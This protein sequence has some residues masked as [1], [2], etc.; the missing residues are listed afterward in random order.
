[1]KP[2]YIIVAI[3]VVVIILYLY[4]YETYTNETYSV[5]S[6]YNLI[7]VDENG[8]MSTVDIHPPALNEPHIPPLTN[9]VYTDTSGNLGVM[10]YKDIGGS[11]RNI[12]TVDLNN[13]NNNNFSVLTPPTTPS[14]TTYT[15]YFSSSTNCIFTFYVTM[16]PNVYPV[17][18]YEFKMNGNPVNYVLQDQSSTARS[19]T[20]KILKTFT[21]NLH[22]PTPTLTK[23]TPTYS[24]AV[25]VTNALGTSPFSAASPAIKPVY[26][27]T[28]I[29]SGQTQ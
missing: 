26:K 13:N 3:V 16:E 18:G 10:A 19:T 11:N 14:I 7:V 21:L 9:I 24:F 20:G 27:P 15:P 4:F 17:T 28:Q 6:P 23:P 25:K 8:N 2:L 1:M 22:I 12:L 29:I 5:G